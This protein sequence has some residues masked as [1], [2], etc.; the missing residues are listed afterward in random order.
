MR[1]IAPPRGQVDANVFDRPPFSYWREFDDLLRSNAWP[2][3]D[4]LNARCSDPSMPRFVAQTPEL[5]TDGLHYESRIAER[6]EIATR[7]DNWH[8]LLN[9]LIWLRYPQLKTAL[10]RRQLAEIAVAGPK[11]RTRAQCALTHFDEAGVIV[12]L[13]DRALLRAWDAH[14]WHDL[15]WNRRQAWLSGEAI[16]IVFGH[17]LLEHALQPAQLLVGKALAII[18]EANGVDESRAIELVAHRIASGRLLSD[19]QE[20]RPLPLSGIPHWI[21]DNKDETFYRTAACFQPLRKGRRYPDPMESVP[22]FRPLRCGVPVCDD[23]VSRL[24]EIE[25]V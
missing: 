8:D 18:D 25:G 2:G 10:N 9:A 15:F 19:P 21:A 23:T 11:T 5:K 4:A 3:I 17:A 13:R 6:G 20:L 1:F 7:Q 12:V 14:D 16:A 24:R 22:G